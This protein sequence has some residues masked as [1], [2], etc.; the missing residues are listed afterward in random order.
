VIRDE[1]SLDGDLLLQH[2]DAAMYAAV[3]F[4]TG[5]AD[6]PK[7]RSVADAV[8]RLGAAFQLTVVAEGIETL[9]QETLLPEIGC[10]FGQGF[11]NRRPVPGAD[12]APTRSQAAR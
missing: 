5:I 10:Q 12:I 4:V 7:A 2:A 8:V 6:D 1:H 9:A 11:Y 3:S